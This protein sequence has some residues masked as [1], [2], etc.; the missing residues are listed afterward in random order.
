DLHAA[1]AGER[2][3]LRREALER[4]PRAGREPGEERR[5]EARLAQV[6]EAAPPGAQVAQRG[7]EVLVRRRGEAA[8]RRV[9]RGEGDARD[10]RVERALLGEAAHAARER[11]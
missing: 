7:R 3:A 5:L 2:H 8:L 9:A 10:E 1:P 4:G 6:G 11:R